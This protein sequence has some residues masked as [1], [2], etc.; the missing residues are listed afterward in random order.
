MSEPLTER[1]T[2]ILRLI[3]EL[4]E[5]SGF[6]P[7]RAEI[8]E[9]TTSPEE[10]KKSASK[11][12]ILQAMGLAPD[13]RVAIANPLD[14]SE[15]IPIYNLNRNRLGQV[16]QVDRNSDRNRRWYNGFDVGFNARVR[17][18]SM[19]GGMSVGRQITV[20]C[21][22][23]DPNSLR[24]CDQREL[25]IPHLTQFKLA[26]TYP[27]PYG[28]QISGTWQGYPGVP[29]GTARQDAE[30]DPAIR[31]DARIPNAADSSERRWRPAFS[32]SCSRGASSTA[33]IPKPPW[34]RPRRRG[35]YV[36]VLGRAR[37]RWPGF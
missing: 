18:G 13:V 35:S 31:S 21:E 16:Q 10:A 28:I 8:A 22:V 32:L 1:Q 6:P 12:V 25:D 26:G 33:S 2:E 5:V 29:T 19:Y 4:T 34:P 17:G 9:R 14:P 7:T 23:E 27:L 3:K 30:Y 20:Q 36:T 15:Q 11:N 37:R 24:F